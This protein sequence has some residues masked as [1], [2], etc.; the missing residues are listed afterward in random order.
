TNIS[1]HLH[2]DDTKV[3]ISSSSSDSSIALAYLSHAL[4]S[5]YTWLTLNR[6]SINPNK[7]EFLLIGTQQQCSKITNS[8][9]S[10]HGTALVP[11]S[12][13]RKLGVVFQSNIFFDQRISNVSLSSFCHIRQ[14]RQIQPSLDLNSSIHFAN[15]LASSKI[16]Y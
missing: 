8:S 16:D 7:T 12:S 10:F 4:D 6:R 13:A 1:V 14:L 15:A 11:A 2:A 9:L 3:Y 5:V